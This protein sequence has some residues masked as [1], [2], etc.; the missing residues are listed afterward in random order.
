MLLR[1]FPRLVSVR[2]SSGGSM[3]MDLYA[4]ASLIATPPLKRRERDCKAGTHRYDRRLGEAVASSEE[5]V[6]EHP[7]GKLGG[8]H[9]RLKGQGNS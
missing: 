2:V 9:L 6:L 3:A 4:I 1:G 5:G 8:L 7:F